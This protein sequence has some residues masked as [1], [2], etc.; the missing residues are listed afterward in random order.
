[1]PNSKPER[2]AVGR[3]DDALVFDGVL[4]RPV[5]ASAWRQA[6]ALLPGVTRLD[7][8]ATARIDSAG[9]AMLVALARQGA[10]ADVVGMPTGYAELRAAYRLDDAL[11]F[12]AG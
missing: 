3:R 9:L 5:V 10:I 4:T 7:L 8:T 12:A 6:Q 11:G 1:M 2:V